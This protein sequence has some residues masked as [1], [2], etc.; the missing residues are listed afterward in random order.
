MNCGCGRG[1]VLF[2]GVECVECASV[3]SVDGVDRVDWGG[4]EEALVN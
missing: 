4:V 1:S 2:S 3:D